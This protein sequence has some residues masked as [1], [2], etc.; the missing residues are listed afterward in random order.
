ML[1]IE[2]SYFRTAAG[3]PTLRGMDKR[4]FDDYIRRFNAQDV[5]A[6]DDYI[7]P[8]LH[9]TNGTLE[10]YGRRG[11]KDHYQQ[12]IWV[13]FTETLNVPRFVSDADTVAIQM[14]AHFRAWR[15]DGASLFGPVREGETF[16]FTGLIMYRLADAQF[17]DIRVAY[18]SFI[19]T[20]LDGVQTSLGIPHL[21]ALTARLAAHRCPRPARPA[22][23][24]SQRARCDIEHVR[25]WPM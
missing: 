16:D 18:N 25:A 1:G 22:G 11:M 4:A 8:D 3:P 19:H 13:T 23:R 6:F 2:N 20:G 15:D 7:H 10:F 5:T 17:I 12:R 9:M 14:L 21:P 24:A